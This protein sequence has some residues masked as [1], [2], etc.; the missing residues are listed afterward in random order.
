MTSKTSR[1]SKVIA[2][3]GPSG[4]GKSTMAK[5]LASKLNILFIDTGAMFRALGYFAD[6]QGIEF[7]EGPELSTFLR[8][9]EMDYNDNPDEMIKINGKNLSSH[10]REHRV[11]TLASQIS[12][13]PSVRTYLLN[14]QRNLGEHSIC[15]MEGRDIGTVV[16]PDSF[17]KI[18][19]T[20]S[21][22]VRA[23]RRFD[24]IRA[25]NPKSDET[26]EQVLADVIERDRKDTQREVAPLKVA[27]GAV[28][29]DT[30]EMNADEVLEELIRISREKAKQNNLSL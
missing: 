22:E 27:E 1:V 2:I 15:V 7:K 20:A 8:E 28:V 3:D 4:S 9:I 17:C 5:N 16:F 21:P 12:Q 19:I 13:L 6:L 24:Q 18:F 29:V 26:Y 11:S 14:F 30:S 25:L 23:G 10:I